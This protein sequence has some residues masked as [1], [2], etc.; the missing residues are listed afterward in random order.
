MMVWRMFGFP[1][2]TAPA[3]SLPLLSSYAH[4]S[5]GAYM[6]LFYLFRLLVVWLMVVGLYALSKIGAIQALLASSFLLV[7]PAAL[8]IL[9]L[10][11][12]GWYPPL[13]LLNGVAGVGGGEALL[14]VAIAASALAFVVAYAMLRRSRTLC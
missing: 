7:V 1:D 9:G 6:L 13:F 8:N 14:A 12:F 11:A 10:R 4:L 5:I 3:C 2:F